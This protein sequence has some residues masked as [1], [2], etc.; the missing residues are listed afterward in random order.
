MNKDRPPLPEGYL[1]FEELVICNNH[2]INV[3]VPIEFKKNIPLLIGRGDVPLVWLSAPITQEAKEWKEIVIK[4]KPMDKKITVVVSKENKSTIIMVDNHI[5][6]HVIKYSEKKA[7][8][9]SLDLRPFGFNIHGNTN[10]LF[11]GTNKFVNNS[12]KNL[13]AMIGIG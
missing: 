4:N 7:E 12:F 13:W 2:L 9:I 1:P 5:I 10:M 8:V 6:V 11:L 3:K